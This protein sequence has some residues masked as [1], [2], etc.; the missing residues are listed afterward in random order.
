MQAGAI[1]IKEIKGQPEVWRRCLKQLDAMDLKALVGDKSPRTH[2]WVFVGCGTSYYLAQAAAAS[3]TT[4]LGVRSHAVPASEALIYPELAFP[5]ESDFFPVLISRSGHTSEVLQVAD[6]L[7]ESG[8]PFLGVTCD[9]R[10]LEQIATATLKLPVVEEST[11]MTSSFTSM[12][13]ALQYIAASYADD[14]EFIAAL[15][16]LPDALEKLLPIYTPQIEQFAQQTFEDIAMLGQGALYPIASEA[17]LKV[18]ESSSSY[19]QYFHAMEFRHGPKSIISES[20]L[21]G[22]LISET[23]YEQE[24]PVLKEMKALGARTLAIAN[25]ISPDVRE[26]ADLAIELDLAV[27]ELARLVMYLV[28][29][30]L[31][32][33]YVGLC[34]GMNP[35]EP[36]HLSRVVTI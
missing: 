22:A 14:K 15:H 17:S 30:Q 18:M 21:V 31:L 24:A 32:G 29:C 7:Q 27:P 9:G 8:V 16:T 28:W 19:A 3:F 13:M 23:G 25:K 36:R 33:S 20:V 1:T 5:A 10:E 2:E 34:K 35:D 11:V 26:A 12:L 4:L 6:L